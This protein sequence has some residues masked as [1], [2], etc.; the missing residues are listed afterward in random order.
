MASL[1]PT[2]DACACVGVGLQ[3]GGCSLAAIGFMGR[4]WGG[5]GI[6]GPG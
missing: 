3:C 1:M 5:D 4:L 2:L 6:Y